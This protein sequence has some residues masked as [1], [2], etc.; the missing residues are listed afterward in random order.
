MN[1]PQ[2]RD[3]A[4]PDLTQMVA[5]YGARVG[6]VGCGPAGISCATYLARLGY[7]DVTVMERK[8][9]SGGLRSVSHQKASFRASRASMEITQSAAC[10]TA[11]RDD[12]ITNAIKSLVIS[13]HWNTCKSNNESYNN[14][15][16]IPGCTVRYLKVNIIICVFC[17]AIGLFGTQKGCIWRESNSEKDLERLNLQKWNDCICVGKW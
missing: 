10:L 7:S 1:I 5:S 9:Y 12:Q 8:D 14:I 4:L 11:C 2:I 17:F 6:V 3:P 16:I 13:L 15:A